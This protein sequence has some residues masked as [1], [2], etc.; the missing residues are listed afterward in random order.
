MSIF[1][2]VSASQS[3]SNQVQQ[4]IFI[5]DHWF[6]HCCWASLHLHCDVVSHITNTRANIINIRLTA[7]HH[8][9]QGCLVLS[10][11]DRC[12]CRFSFQPNRSH[13]W[14]YW[15]P[16]SGGLGCGFCSMGMKTCIHPDPLQI[17]LEILDIGYLHRVHQYLHRKSIQNWVRCM[18][19]LVVIITITI[20]SLV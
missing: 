5:T 1:G 3:L 14:V 10:R 6:N 15:K 8:I 20:K 19:K 17:R 12:G 16:G 4:D 11:K 2:F 7:Y 13:A 9:G 18:L